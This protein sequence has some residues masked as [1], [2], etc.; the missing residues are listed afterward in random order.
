MACATACRAHQQRPLASRD[1]SEQPV[2]FREEFRMPS[3]V[4][5]SPKAEPEAIRSIIQ[6]VALQVV[7]FDAIGL[8]GNTPFPE[9]AIRRTWRCTRCGS[10]EVTVMP[11]WSDPRGGGRPG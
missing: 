2:R 4:R 9:I 10:N 3:G 1:T 8:P 7:S 6:I 5:K 11:N